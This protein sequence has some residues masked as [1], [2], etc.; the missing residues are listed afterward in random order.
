[1]PERD[2]TSDPAGELAPGTSSAPEPSGG[3][4]TPR[5]ETG[6]RNDRREIG[7][8]EVL[9]A[10]AETT[11]TGVRSD[12]REIGETSMLRETRATGVRPGNREI[13][14]A[15]ARPET[16]ERGVRTDRREIGEVGEIGVLREVGEIGVLREAGETDGAVPLPE[17]VAEVFAQW[18]TSDPP[19]GFADRVISAALGAEPAEPVRRE[20]RL[21]RWSQRYSSAGAPGERPRGRVARRAIAAVIGALIAVA[22]SLA[23][24]R[25]PDRVPA[26]GSRVV[27]QRET[28]ALGARAVAVAEADAELT[29]SVAAGSAEVHQTR[30]EVFYRVEPGGPFVVETP[31]GQVIV[32]G[33][34]FRVEVMD[35]RMSRQTWI[36]GGVGAA[37]AAAVVVTLYEGHVRVV[38]ARGHRDAEPGD[39]IALAAGT[40]PI[41]LGAASSGRAV[42]LEPPPP[43]TASVEE[44]LRR[45]QTH[46]G[47]IAM[48]RARVAAL[49]SGAP[50]APT[51]PGAAHPGGR[52]AIVDIAPQDLAEMARNCEIRFDV[53][54]YGIEPAVM[55]DQ[56]AAIDQLSGD[57]RAIYDRIARQESARYMAAL[58]A[59]YQELV[60]GDAAET[61]EAHAIF[62]EILR[63]SPG[64]EVEVARKQLAAERAG[65][66]AAPV[67]LRNHSVA[68]RMF[69]LEIDAAGTLEQRLAAELGPARAHQIRLN[70]W[71]GGDDAVLYGCPE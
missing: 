27:H 17:R 23:V 32:R 43:G 52:R 39:R 48:L 54:G 63:K 22:V 71:P 35:M 59:L 5:A 9:P 55:T 46:R 53:P 7:E 18:A 47:E 11:E 14:E 26:Q 30:G 8:T 50:E 19:E 15:G 67:D 37:L 31:Y 12:R 1:M 41:A 57:E 16:A 20:G 58:R 42:A 61:L 49:Q 65:L 3:V 10:T 6:V 33:T 2:A 64:G 29:W 70:G 25:D 45:D 51:V 36:S 13:G 56:R 69:R 68:E 28:I 40:A 21:A 62:T 44:L 66:A 34:C 38:N 60:G 4:S 24:L